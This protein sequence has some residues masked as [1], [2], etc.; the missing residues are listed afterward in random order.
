MKKFFTL[1]IVSVQA[2]YG[3]WPFDVLFPK[4]REP[5]PPYALEHPLM[6]EH[7]VYGVGNGRSF[8]EAKS[9]A[10][11]DIAIQLR[12]DVRSITSVHKSSE[13]GTTSDQQITVLTNRLLEN[14][15]VIQEDHPN[16]EVYLLIE[17]K[18]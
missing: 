11:N 10:L 17:Y 13:A 18:R 5:L 14:Y 8:L 9:K 16:G 4:E 12:S 2:V 3:F 6:D 7:A 15:T 1:L